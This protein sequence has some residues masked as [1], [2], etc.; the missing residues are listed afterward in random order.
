M[1][2][3]AGDH[4]SSVDQMRAFAQN[5]QPGPGGVDELEFV[6][7][8]EI[9][10]EENP[11]EFKALSTA[12]EL[13][14]SMT[15]GPDP[16]REALERRRL[17]AE[18]AA[19]AKKRYYALAGSNQ[20]HFLQPRGERSPLADPDH[21]LAV[22][23][24]LAAAG[25][26]A[27][28]VLVGSA[29]NYRNYHVRAIKEAVLA[30]QTGS[31]PGQ[32]LAAEAFGAHYLTDS[33]SGG[34]VETE[35]LSISEYWNSR[36]PMFFENLV[37]W[38]AETMAKAVAATM[39]LGPFQ[40]RP[41]VA[42][43]FGARSKVETAFASKGS[44]TFGDLVSGAVHDA[45]NLYGV[46]AGVETG[47]SSGVVTLYGDSHLGEGDEEELAT[48]AVARG[49]AD[50]DKAFAMAHERPSPSVSMVLAKLVVDGQFPPEQLLPRSLPSAEPVSAPPIWQFPTA[51]DLFNDPVMVDAIRV[52]AK[53]KASELESA[54][55]AFDATQK[56][57]FLERIVN[58]FRTDPIGVLRTVL[59]WTP[60]TGG[61]ALGHNTD[62]NALDYVEAVRKA[63]GLATLSLDQRSRL[64]RDLLEGAT[65]GEDEDAVMDLLTSASDADARALID[66]FGWE[67]IHDDIDDFAGEAFAERFPK[68]R[69]GP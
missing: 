38:I 33:F 53:E 5:K 59:A 1:V 48:E 46:Q 24:L 60:A 14:L 69:Y 47:E 43:H 7:R 20:S 36:V 45:A 23:E 18:A 26:P 13:A 56:A 35:R 27:A 67:R 34:H 19:A 4:F 25:I 21:A 3:M 41:D 42:Y 65:I 12:E 39:T 17:G 63:N 50:I 64:V 22:A 57:L 2:A 8:V 55:S 16:A 58:P 11:K 52:F 15:P 54:A 44:F 62:D 29:A 10:G 61:G 66:Q 68:S 49:V 40:L 51:D 28:D 32:A 31:D 6:R 9:H 30:G 37:G